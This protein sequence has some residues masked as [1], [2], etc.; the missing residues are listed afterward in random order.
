MMEC[1]NIGLGSTFPS[2]QKSPEFSRKIQQ[3]KPLF[4]TPHST[5]I[6]VFPVQQSQ[7]KAFCL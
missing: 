3:E 4:P 7:G 2:L 5:D 6:P 1:W